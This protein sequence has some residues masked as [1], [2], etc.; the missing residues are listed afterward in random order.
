MI[1]SEGL[2]PDTIVKHSFHPVLRVLAKIIS[3]L[4]HPLFI[5]VYIGW[6]LIYEVMLFPGQDPWHKT[7]LIIQFF[8][9]YTL[10]PLVT[11]LLAKALGF[12]KSI[13]LKNQRD[14]IIPYV[15]CEIFY[16]WVWYVFRNQGYPREVVLF[17]LGVFL[18]SCIGLILNSYM[19]VS[20]HALS[21]GA[22]SAF[23]LLLAFSGIMNMGYYLSVTFLIAGLV[24]TA[25]MITGD[26]IQQ[27]IYIGYFAGIAALVIASFFV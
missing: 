27:E 3:Y 26:H 17:G 23:M 12:I 15:M 20:M 2:S 13:F 7:L 24:C 22:V 21:V 19:K 25:R 1:P 9:S 10:L 6:F 14:R 16:F 18:T 11:I 5:P 8:V 4:F